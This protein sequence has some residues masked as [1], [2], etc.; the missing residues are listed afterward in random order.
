M[1]GWIIDQMKKLYEF[2]FFCFFCLVLFNKT[3]NRVQRA[4]FGMAMFSIIS[5]NIV[6][7]LT[8]TYIPGIKL[9]GFIIGPLM[10]I[11][12]FYLYYFNIKYF[13]KHINKESIISQFTSIRT[14]K[15]YALIGGLLL[16]LSLILFGFVGA[17][18]SPA[19]VGVVQQN[20]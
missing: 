18:Y 2:F 12:I 7:I 11:L 14:D 15:S 9:N 13:E 20:D 6:I 19:L 3:D 16:L 17:N 5:I 4:A 10:L 8:L 1:V